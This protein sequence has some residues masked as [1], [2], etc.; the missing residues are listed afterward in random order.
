MA[1]EQEQAVSQVA[2]LKL[3]IGIRSKEGRDLLRRRMN[4]G[5]SGFTLLGILDALAL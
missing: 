5:F 2:V 1:T 4:D 3:A